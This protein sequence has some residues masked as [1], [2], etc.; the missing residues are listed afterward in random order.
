MRGLYCLGAVLICGSWLACADQEAKPELLD[1][2]R[3]DAGR[4]ASRDGSADAARTD[5]A[6]DAAPASRKL[7][8]NDVSV[9]WPAPKT[10]ALPAGYLK[11]FP[12]A[13]E[14]G[15][16]IASGARVVFEPGFHADVP[17]HI[18]ERT[19]AV[20]ALRVDPCA[21]RANGACV[22]ELRLSA[23]PFD[24]AFDDAATHL[25]YELSK[26]DFSAMASELRA[27][28]AASPVPTS[29]PLRVHPGLA[30]AGA[31]SAYW[32][33]WNSFVIKW[34]TAA[35]MTRVTVNS[36]G[37][38]NWFFRG[39]EKASGWSMDD[40]K[41]PS[42]PAANARTQSW[43]QLAQHE[44]LNDPSGKID[45]APASNFGALL[46]ANVNHRDPAF[47][48]ALDLL[49]K[50][51]HPNKLTP[52]NA[53]CVSCHLAPQA[54]LFYEARGASLTAATAYT[55]PAGFDASVLVVPELRGNMSNTIM[56][57]WHRDRHTGAFASV[58]ERVV[59]ETAETLRAMGEL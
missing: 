57:G 7:E 32:R 47:K 18:V 3:S 39:V 58:A 54:A 38:D 19:V 24:E 29:G 9:L 48:S 16:G 44:N 22:P 59:F 50:F 36:F 49:G 37:L 26:P 52:A 34:A 17:P 46:A 5:S 6:V 10:G 14:Q 53:D 1:D 25:I 33:S 35:R 21:P 43:L 12:T 42:L 55:P 23:E 13:S 8:A 30:A 27:L 31:N 4:D 15:P 28:K 40:F 56:F 11:V 2:L 51:K 41:I 20:L 45:P